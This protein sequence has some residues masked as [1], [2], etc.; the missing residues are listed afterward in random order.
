MEI[1][2]AIDL[3]QA[4]QP[5]F[6]SG[7]GARS[8]APQATAEQKQAQPTPQ[9]LEKALQTINQRLANTTSLEFSIDQDTRI[10]VVKVIDKDSGELIRQIPP[11]ATLAIAESVSEFQKGLLLRQEA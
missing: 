11:D 3:G 6:R 1:Q 7:V 9:Q 2:N 5:E 10:A 4:P 8:A